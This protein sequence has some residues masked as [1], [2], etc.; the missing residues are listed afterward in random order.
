[1]L[2]TIV[3]LSLFVGLINGR[4]AAGPTDATALLNTADGQFRQGRHAD[5]LR[6]YQEALALF[7]QMGDRRGEAKA[8]VGIGFAE[9]YQG[10]YADA[11]Q[12]EQQ[13]LAL[14]RHQSDPEEEATARTVV[15]L[16]EFTRC[17]YPVASNRSATRITQQE[18]S[19]EL[20]R[21]SHS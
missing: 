2:R 15:G 7:R 11:L 4:V 12:T 13:A 6:S 14:L 5:A 1:M 3:L 18:P 8:L 16:V 19:R 17:Q 10:Q 20:A 21:C 9:L